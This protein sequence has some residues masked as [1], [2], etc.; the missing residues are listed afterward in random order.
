MRL[1]PV[2]SLAISLMASLA[3]AAPLTLEQALQTVDQGGHPDEALFLADTAA[4]RA[5]MLE[6]QSRTDWT[7]TLDGV[8]RQGVQPYDSSQWKSDNQA[9]LTARYPL[10][11]AGRSG[12]RIRAAQTDMDARNT[13]F[14][15]QRDQRRY[16]VMQ[17]FFAVLLADLQFTA[18]N[19]NMAVQYVSFDQSRD[20]LKQGQISR[21]D[22]AENEARY[23]DSML[24][25]NASQLQQRITRAR[26]AESMNQ[27]GKLAGDL[28][29]PSLDSLWQKK[30]PDVTELQ[31]LAEQHNPRLQALQQQLQAEEAR[32]A[33]V[34]AD[35]KPQLD[36]ELQAADY[37]RP[38]ATRDNLSAGVVL[39]IPLWQGRREDARLA[40]EQ[41]QWQKL[42]AQRE[43]LLM[44]IQQGVLETALQIEQLQGTA[45][46][47]A[48][49]M[50]D[51][52]DLALERSRGLYE[53][54]LK[55]NLGTSMVEVMNA[56]VRGKKVQYELALAWE[57]L[58]NLV[59]MELN[60]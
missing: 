41:A 60:Q 2:V 35:Y 47:A 27:P 12:E 33:G 57:R 52:R 3:S 23:Q 48:Q 28:V 40:R 55:T 18:D 43:R 16:E 1:L 36:V 19:E 38:A 46:S 7:V 20:K 29:E 26:L 11:D 56:A 22:V 4:V 54:E 10:L 39:T 37:A 50:A 45:R 42:Q 24:A 53:L 44:D 6:A 21:V 13:L 8:L 14:A 9:R 51:Y 58:R 5:D 59:G 17:R 25:R 49:K 30:L 15:A 31:K 34:R 32:M